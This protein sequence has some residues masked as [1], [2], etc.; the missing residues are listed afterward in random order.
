[1]KA[2]LLAATALLALST[3]A[4]AEKV[5]EG[6][7][8]DLR[9]IGVSIGECDLNKI[10][11]QDFKRIK[12][13]CGEPFAPAEEDSLDKSV[14]WCRVVFSGQKILSILRRLEK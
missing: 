14:P 12:S 5:C 3:A 8:T 13:V 10:S 1:M 7:F 9:K 11:E 4:H 6:Q 2:L